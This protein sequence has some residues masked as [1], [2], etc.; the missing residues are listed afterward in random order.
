[1]ATSVSVTESADHTT[2]LTSTD[3][4]ITTV[5]TFVTSSLAL[6]SISISSSTVTTIAP[7]STNATLSIINSHTLS[8][9]S[10]SDNN[11]NNNS[12]S[13][14]VIVAIIIVVLVVVVFIIITVVVVGIIVVWLRNKS[15]Q[16]TKPESVY[17]STI[18][19][20]TLPR[21][22]TSKPE[23]VYN[24]MNDGQQENKEPEYM[25]IPEGIHS[26]KQTNKV[27]MQDNPAYSIPSEHQVE[28]QDNP[29]YSGVITRTVFNE[30]K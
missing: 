21:S 28:I 1:M 27:T 23:P 8:S 25:D 12:S 10:Q 18:D 20:T 29:A 17:Y 3:I 16:H 11:N 30:V 4:P 9:S 5:T 2:S 14:G 19:E 15:E 26:T 13:V 22:P 7:S 24:E 6:G